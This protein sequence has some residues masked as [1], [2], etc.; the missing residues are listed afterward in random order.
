MIPHSVPCIN[1]SESQKG[2]ETEQSTANVQMARAV[3]VV[4]VRHTGTQLT[5]R[6]IKQKYALN[7]E[8]QPH[9]KEGV[10]K[11]STPACAFI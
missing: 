3:G 1:R 6:S 7:L 8:H 10:C 9:F 5:S 11:T 4:Q 2:R